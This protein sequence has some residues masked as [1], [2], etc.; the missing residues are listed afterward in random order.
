MEARFRGI[1]WDRSGYD[2]R[3]HEAPGTGRS[4]FTAQVE[5]RVDQWFEADR[6]LANG[7]AVSIWMQETRGIRSTLAREIVEQYGLRDPLPPE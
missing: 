1:R 6:R 5:A 2:D 3:P 7:R 4:R